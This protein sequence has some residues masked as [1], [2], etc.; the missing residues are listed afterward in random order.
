ML[1]SIRGDVRFKEPISFYTSLRLGG[2]ADILIM[3]QD[4]DDIR[5]ALQFVDLLENEMPFIEAVELYLDALQ[6]RDSISEV[7]AYMALSRLADEHLPKPAQS[8]G[9]TTRTIEVAPP[10]R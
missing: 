3:P 8:S 1:G 5:H 4:V 10:Q 6:V 9:S 7:T 2:P